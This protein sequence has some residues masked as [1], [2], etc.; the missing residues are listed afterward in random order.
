MRE[1]HDASVGE[2]KGIMVCMRIIEIDLPESRNFV[3]DRLSG[4]LR[5]NQLKGG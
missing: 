1:Q 2:L 5:K 4:F 3:A